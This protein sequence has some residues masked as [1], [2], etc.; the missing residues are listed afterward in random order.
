MEEALTGLTAA[1]KTL[2]PKWLYDDR[3][4]ALFEEITEVP[5]YYPTRTEAAIFETMMPHLPALFPAGGDIIEYGSGASKKTVALIETL[6]PAIYRPLDIAADFLA[7]AAA[8]LQAQFPNIAVKP[9]VADFTDPSQIPATEE[10]APPRLGFFP[11]STIGNLTD[12]QRHTFLAGARKGLGDGA[13]FLLGADLVKDKTV[14]EA[15]Y[16][17]AV[18]GSAALNLN[19][20]TR[21]NREL[22]T[23]FDVSAFE[24]KA[25]FNGDASRIE[26]HLVSLGSQTVS[27][28]GKSIPFADGET[29]HT[30]NSYKFTVDMIDELAAVTGWRLAQTWT[31]PKDWFGV[32]WLEAV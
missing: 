12:D 26:M 22:G 16:D 4:S 21:M 27:L 25:L 14:L 5:E 6:R 13:R 32:F 1:Q 30:E 11:G 19:L 8:G 24:H 3:G 29:I 9:V 10:G 7:Q 15:A 28:G 18:C 23:N 17:D 2:S 31:D 20:L